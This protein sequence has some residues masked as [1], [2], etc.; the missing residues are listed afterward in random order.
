MSH[1][2]AT[3]KDAS[4][5]VD[6]TIYCDVLKKNVVVKDYHISST[7]SE[8]ETC[9]SHGDVTLN[10]YKCECGKSHDIEINSW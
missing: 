5:L 3:K 10:V 4:K 8:C 9:G 7:S 6:I 1:Y 2:N